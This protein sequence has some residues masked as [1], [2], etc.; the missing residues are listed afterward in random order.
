MNI[1]HF[2]IKTPKVKAPGEDGWEQLPLGYYW[3]T[4]CMA[5]DRRLRDD[6]LYS[7]IRAAGN[8]RAGNFQQDCLLSIL[9]DIKRDEV[10]IFELGAGWGRICLNIAGAI[11]F[12]VT[13]CTPKTYHCL[14]VEAEPIHYE[15]L[16]EHF[17]AQNI[18]GT[19]VFGTVSNK[20]GS[21]HFDASSRPDYQYGQAMSPF[22]SRI[23][24]PSIQNLRKIITGKTVKVPT[25]TLDRLVQEYGFNHVD[26]VQMDVQG[27]EYD[28]IKG[29]ANS[30]KECMIDYFLINIHL[31]KYS[32]MLPVLLSDKYNLIIDLKRASLG[33][34][35]GFPPIHCNDG[36]QLYKRKASD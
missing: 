2:D 9:A 17:E 7:K 12:K 32:N 1:R 13:Q 25:Y 11:D 8:M 19:A 36:I 10:N 4:K 33:I 29:A 31:E 24:I 16:K 27:A 21:S 20:N 3:M 18:N 23:G 6:E 28:V 14:A 30:I 15:W 5:A 35:E 22:M 34:V 26:I